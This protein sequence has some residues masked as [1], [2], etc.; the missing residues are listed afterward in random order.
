MLEIVT[1][2]PAWVIVLLVSTTFYCISFCFEKEVSIKLLLLIPGCFM[3]FSII[4]ILQQ[5]NILVS[6]LVWLLGCI[7]GGIV[8]KRIFHL[9]PTV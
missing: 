6:G 7:L 1:G 8:A 2:M 3:I 9:K 4:S 5:G